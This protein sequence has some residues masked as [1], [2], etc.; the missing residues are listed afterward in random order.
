MAEI[1]LGVIQ[2]HNG[3]VLR[4]RWEYINI[5][6]HVVE[7]YFICGYKRSRRSD[8]KLSSGILRFF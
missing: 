6:G 2:E 8:M 7:R 3:N 1:N 4:L 5:V